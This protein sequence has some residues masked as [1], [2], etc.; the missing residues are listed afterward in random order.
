MVQPGRIESLKFVHRNDRREVR[1]AVG[2]T[3]QVVRE[4]D[5]RLIAEQALDL[6]PD[7]MLVASEHDM[8]VGESLIVSFKAT[9]LGLWFDT[10][11]SVARIIKGRRPGD[12]GAGLGLSFSSLDRVK[13]LI[14]RGH[15]RRVPPPLPRRTQRIDW[16]AT[17]RSLTR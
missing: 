12:R 7:G 16:T 3:C 5:F 9:Q 15:L 8:A 14:L 2:L 17:V 1:R 10:E 6:S 13:R 11:A 4:R